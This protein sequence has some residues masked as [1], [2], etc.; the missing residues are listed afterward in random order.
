MAANDNRM[1]WIR[2]L[3]ILTSGHQQ[4]T[5]E[6]ELGSECYI[7]GLLDYGEGKI[8][9]ALMSTEE[10]R[11]GLWLYNLALQYPTGPHDHTV[12]ADEK[13][14]YFKDGIFGELLALLSVFFRCRFFLIS[15]RLVPDNPRQGMTLKTEYPFLW[16]KCAPDIHPPLFQAGNKN[17]AYRFPQFLDLV[18]T[19]DQSLHQ[20]FILAC[21]HYSRAIKEVGIDTEMVFIRLVSAI[22]ALSKDVQLTRKDDVLEQRGVADLIAGSTLP[23]DNRTELQNVFDVRKSRKK[24]I[25]F[26]EE[27]CSGFFKGGNFRAR[28]TKIKRANLAK[29]LDTIYKARSKYLHAGEPMFLSTPMRGGEKWDTDPTLGMVV[30][31]RSFPASQKLPYT[32]FFEGLV[33]QCLLN[34]LKINSSL[35]MAE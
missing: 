25:R 14:Y 5:V 32:Y 31:N 7:P 6:Y 29:I 26:V 21:H 9:C 22:E 33:R 20:K 11:D 16:V 24:F 3:E 35:Q 10:S 2:N 12:Q 30:G 15:S 8:I 34:Y 28:H 17:L 13:G 4:Y 19:L 23:A 27:H 18:T 1:N